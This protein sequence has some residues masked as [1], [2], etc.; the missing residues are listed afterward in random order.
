MSV[1]RV[2]MVQTI[3][4]LGLT[5]ENVVHFNNPDGAL[6]GAAIGAELQANFM[7]KIQ[8][9][10][11]NFLGWQYFYIYRV[12]HPEIPAYIYPLSN[13]PG[14]STAQYM[15]PTNCYKLKWQCLAGGRHGRGRFYIAGGR[16]DWA[17]NYGITASAVTN[18]GI[19]L[20]QIVARYKLGGTG[21]LTLGL[22]EK[23]GGES[24]FTALDSAVFWQYIGQQRRRQY[25]VGI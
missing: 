11:S 1:H 24:T 16:S 9:W 6:S 8:G 12:G 2:V 17:A 5:Y 10:Q 4:L 25:G 13:S 22:V 15:Y 19:L 20:G 18:G 14:L 3:P 23:G 7:P 21:P